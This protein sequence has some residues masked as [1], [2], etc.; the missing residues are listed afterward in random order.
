VTPAL[1]LDRLL[2]GLEAQVDPAEARRVGLHVL[3]LATRRHFEG[4]HKHT[5]E[6]TR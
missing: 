5:R 3:G 2:R 6:A 1:W 4:W